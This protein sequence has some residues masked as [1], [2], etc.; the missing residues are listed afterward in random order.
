MTKDFS[1]SAEDVIPRKLHYCW[2]GG[3]EKPAL[4]QFCIRSWRKY[5]PDFEIVEWNENNFEVNSLPIAA[6]AYKRKKYAFVSD[7]VRAHVLYYH[8]GIY[9]DADV[10]IRRDLSRFLVHRAFTG[11]ERRGTPFTA[12]WGGVPGHK[13]ALMVLNYYSAIQPEDVINVP[14]TFFVT[15]LLRDHFGVDCNADELQNCAEGLVVYP[16]HIFCVDIPENY[17]THHFAGSWLERRAPAHWSQIVLASFYLESLK[18][19]GRDVIMST[20]LQSFRN[21]ISAEIEDFTTERERIKWLANQLRQALFRVMRRR[22][23]GSARWVG[24]HVLPGIFRMNP[25]LKGEDSDFP[26]GREVRAKSTPKH[27]S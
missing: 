8:G 5:C 27:H 23:S 21:G 24:S 16:S 9:L 22:I 4:I 12:V 15:D 26:R 20:H 6:E 13:L 1:L 14:N 11:F 2:F 17:A 7:F 19:L 25:E 3:N 10:E 18:K